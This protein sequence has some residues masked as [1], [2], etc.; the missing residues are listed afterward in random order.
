MV[1]LTPGLGLVAAVDEDVIT[2]RL[3][4]GVAAADSRIW[5]T[6]VWTSGIIYVRVSASD[7]WQAG[8]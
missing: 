6:V 4:L 1:N 3:I 5:L 2:T 8:R 7:A